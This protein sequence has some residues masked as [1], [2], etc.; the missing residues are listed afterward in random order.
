MNLEKLLNMEKSNNCMKKAQST[1]TV[2]LIIVIAF[3]I[4]ALMVVGNIVYKMLR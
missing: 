4:I 3:I 2:T 1:E